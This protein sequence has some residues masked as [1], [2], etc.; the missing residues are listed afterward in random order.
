M[1]RLYAARIRPDLGLLPYQMP[2]M[3]V[4]LFFLYLGNVGKKHTFFFVRQISPQNQKLKYFTFFFEEQKKQLFCF[5]FLREH[6]DLKI[7]VNLLW[8]T[9]HTQK[10]KKSGIVPDAGFFFPANFSGNFYWNT[11]FSFWSQKVTL[12]GNLDYVKEIERP[13]FLKQFLF[14]TPLGN[15]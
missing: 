6:R 3:G 8:K 15:A 12:K 9:Q 14:D 2:R 10:K 13:L 7:Q 11:G 1:N 5:V 4:R